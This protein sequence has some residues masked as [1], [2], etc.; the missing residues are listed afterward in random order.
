[1]PKPC[2]INSTRNRK[3][4]KY[5]KILSNCLSQDPKVPTIQKMNEDFNPK[6]KNYSNLKDFKTSNYQNIQNKKIQQFS[7]IQK[8]IRKSKS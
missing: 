8:K 7:K 4:L 6:N 1:M 2:K 3:I 5:P